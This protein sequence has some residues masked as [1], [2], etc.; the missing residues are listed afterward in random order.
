MNRFNAEFSYL[1]TYKLLDSKTS[2]IILNKTVGAYR[3]GV[4]KFS[5]SESYVNLVNSMILEAYMEFITDDEV[6]KII[7]KQ[8]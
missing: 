5:S 8:A 1:I 3:K 6:R 2:K 7:K 4:G